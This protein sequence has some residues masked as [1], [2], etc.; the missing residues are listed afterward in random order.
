L[1]TVRK[2]LTKALGSRTNVR[3]TNLDF[4]VQGQ[5]CLKRDA[6]FFLDSPASIRMP[7]DALEPLPGQDLQVHVLCVCV[8]ARARVCVR[9]CVCACVCACVRACVCVC[10]CVCVYLFLV[11]AHGAG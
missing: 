7:K 3:F 11:R 5:V 6:D 9:V 1:Y 4:I 10:V 2:C 8:C